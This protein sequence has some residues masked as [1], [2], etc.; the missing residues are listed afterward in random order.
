MVSVCLTYKKG[1]NVTFNLFLPECVYR[2]ELLIHV[3]G[4]W[5][6]GGGLQGAGETGS[7]SI[8]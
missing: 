6:A 5:F 3:A 1:V 2:S 8:P 7:P 4:R